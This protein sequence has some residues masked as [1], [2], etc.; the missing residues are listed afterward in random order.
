MLE[1]FRPLIP[2]ILEAF[3]KVID[4]VGNEDVVVVFDSLIEKFGDEISPFAAQLVE[5]MVR[6]Q[7]FLSFFFIAIMLFRISR[8]L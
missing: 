1:P 3:F 8:E 4:E 6:R 2:G 7:F 5:R